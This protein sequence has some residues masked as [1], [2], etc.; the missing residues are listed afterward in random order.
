MEN[1]IK[2]A[3]STKPIESVVDN[4]DNFLVTKTIFG[5]TIEIE[6]PKRLLP[7]AIEIEGEVFDPFLTIPGMVN[8]YPG[9]RHV[10]ELENTKTENEELGKESA[11][12][13]GL[14]SGSL[15]LEAIRAAEEKCAMR[16][17]A[18][19]IYKFIN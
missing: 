11:K 9:F 2:F 17:I 12:T 3:N 13:D 7:E 1:Q 8:S 18:E 14:Y 6:F 5:E 15:N 4:G 19:E 10:E 16:T